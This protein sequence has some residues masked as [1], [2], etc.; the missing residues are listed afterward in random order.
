[1]LIKPIDSFLGWGGWRKQAEALTDSS[2]A[3]TWVDSSR[4]MVHLLCFSTGAL[5]SAACSPLLHT[6]HRG[7]EAVAASGR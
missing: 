5:G 4:Y 7:R 6:A 3:S 2:R 1:M